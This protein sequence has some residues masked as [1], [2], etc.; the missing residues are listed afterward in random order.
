[1]AD[2]LKL[3][4][5][6]DEKGCVTGATVSKFA[7]RITVLAAEGRIDAPQLRARAGAPG[8]RA[9]P[10]LSLQGGRT[11]ARPEVQGGRAVRCWAP[12]AASSRREAR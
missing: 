12:Q 11:W 1:M 5:L 3:P 2:L 7:A 10:R 9:P 8:A 4:S 6:L